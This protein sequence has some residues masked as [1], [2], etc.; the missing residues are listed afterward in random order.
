MATADRPTKDLI[1]SVFELDNRELALE[2]ARFG[3]KVATS[4]PTYDSLNEWT[5]VKEFFHIMAYKID[6]ESP[7][8]LLGLPDIDAAIPSGI[9]GFIAGRITTISNILTPSG[10]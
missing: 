1:N 6:E 4:F 2:A 8:S 10:R 3:G 7:W 5:R 9:D